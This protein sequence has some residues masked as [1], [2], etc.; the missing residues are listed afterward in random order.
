MTSRSDVRIARLRWLDVVGPQRFAQQ[1]VIQEIDLADRQV[2]GRA[3]IT[4]EK[5]EIGLI[6]RIFLRRVFAGIYLLHADLT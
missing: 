3:P 1:R 4:V 2:V 5:I 6:G